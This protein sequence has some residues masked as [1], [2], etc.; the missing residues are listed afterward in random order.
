VPINPLDSLLQPVVRDALALAPPAACGI[1]E[2]VRAAGK[3]IDLT[4]RASEGAQPPVA[5]RCGNR[6]QTCNGLRVWVSIVRLN[7]VAVSIVWVGHESS[8]KERI[9]SVIIAHL[10]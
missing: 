9:F 10:L 3:H 2:E 6:P 7:I 8:H 1:H 4:G 5:G